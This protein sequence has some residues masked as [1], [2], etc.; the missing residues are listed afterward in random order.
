VRHTRT[1]ARR[2]VFSPTILAA[3]LATV[4]LASSVRAQDPDVDVIRGR[5][6]R[7]D[8]SGIAGAQVKLTSAASGV[9]RSTRSDAQGRF[10][11][12]FQNGGGDYTVNITSIGFAP[13]EFR[14]RREGEEEVLRVAAVMKPT[15]QNLDAVRIAES[16]RPRAEVI[17]A[18]VGGAG[19]NPNGNAL[20][21]NLQGDLTAMASLIPGFAMLYNADG[22]T[23]GFSA[24]G[25]QANQNSVTM[26][27]VTSAASSIPRDANVYTRIST[28]TADASRGGFSGA[29]TSLTPFG[30]S[31]YT[32]HALRITF[33]DPSFQWSDPAAS[34]LNSQFRNIAV[35]GSATGEIVPEQ[36]LYSVS[37]QFGRRTSPLNTLLSADSAGLIRLGLA[38]DSVK[39]FEQIVQ[40]LGVPFSV[41]ATP[42]ERA[43]QNGSL[44]AR[45]D[46][47]PPN[48]TNGATYNTTINANF[49]NT[50][51]SSLG[52]RVLPSYGG[53]NTSARGSLQG[54]ASMN[55]G[56]DFLN[57]TRFGVDYSSSTGSPY[58]GLPQGSVLVT[59]TDPTGGINLNNLQFGSGSSLSRSSRTGVVSLTDNLSWFN[60]DS[61]HRLKLS[62]DPRYEWYNQLEEANTLGTFSYNSLA[63]LAA[64]TPASFVRRLGAQERSGALAGGS[65]SLTD[66]WRKTN[67]LQFQY[68]LRAD[69]FDFLT[70]PAY[71][72]EIDQLFG[73]HTDHTPNS[74]GVSPR[75]GFSWTVGKAP[76][77]ANTQ[78][79]LTNLGI[80][81]GSV[82]RYWQT[83]GASTISDAFDN[84]GLPSGAQQITC[85]GSSV[86]T[87]NWNSYLTNPASIPTACAD[88][89]TG[90][91]FAVTQPRVSTYDPS[92]QPPSSWRGSLRWASYLTAKMRISFDLQYSL[93]QHQASYVD[94]NFVSTPAFVLANEGG[95]PVYANPGAIVPTT[96]AVSLTASRFSP[97]YA[98]VYNNLGDGQSRS[99]QLTVTL[100]PQPNGICFSACPIYW[101]V[102]W[103]TLRVDDDVRGFGGNT[104]GNPLLFQW[105][106][107]SGDIQHQI[108]FNV[109]KALSQELNLSV[110]GQFRSGV[111]FT[112]TVGGDINGDGS[113][114]DRAFVFNPSTV[115]DTAVA[116]GMRSILASAPA[117]VKAC[118]NAQLGQVAGRNSCRGP[119]MASNFTARLDFRPQWGGVWDRVNMALSFANPLTGVDALVHH[120]QLEGW[121]QPAF[122]DPTLLY[123]RGFNPATNSYIYSVNQ[124]FGE[125]RA[126]LSIPT[127]PFQATLEMRINIGPQPESQQGKMTIRQMKPLGKPA[128][129]ERMIKGRLSGNYQ[130]I[131]T[132][133]LQQKDSLGLTA[134]QV[135]SATKLFT[136]FNAVS[137]SMFAPVAKYLADA[138]RSGADA[139]IGHRVMAVQQKI[140]LPVADVLDAVRLL[141]TPAQ[142]S[143]L[144]VPLSFQL[145]ESYIKYLRDQ[146]MKPIYFGF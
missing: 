99:R 92:F 78:F 144:K 85:I 8:S 118:L 55:V 30:G 49:T 107:S 125:T 94:R 113:Y 52:S 39:R 129:D 33:D 102:S 15:A 58:I 37:Y 23:A 63:D 40:G 43:T 139:E 90:S 120:G 27:G 67:T 36:S 51:A 106:R 7:P 59:S 1:P 64:G 60:E 9:T 73:L 135:D 146:A 19:G 31:P 3:L 5:V 89:T 28:T 132:Q 74:F 66:T 41:G 26:N 124:R 116:S 68:G 25:L 48:S 91:A 10:S 76:K 16:K 128:M 122:P 104:A 20:P 12:I 117:A 14:L 11:I 105:G 93:N 84:T 6:Q 145:D 121:G 88:G 115:T 111:P 42:S 131:L 100:A 127:A 45:F 112:P 17:A 81:S 18:D 87:P 22:T 54:Y 77:N 46:F 136:K 69:A 80:L 21:A 142:R 137:D 4:C 2:W 95:R 13:Q 138:P 61:K 141:L 75:F 130:T 97:D 82:G 96:G 98:Q 62:T 114:N 123:V 34:S 70:H 44:L 86:P 50:G 108:N 109:T 126:A 47:N 71:N 72:P 56:S 140:L 35:S 83:L 24:L 32:R 101:F 110:S 134:Q 79:G 143:K 57:E 29:Q 53:E 38:P 119:W 133:L 103:T 65:I